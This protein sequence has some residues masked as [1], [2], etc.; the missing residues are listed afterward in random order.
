[1]MKKLFAMLLIAT[2]SLTTVAFAATYRY[3]GDDIVFTYDENIFEIVED[4]H[5]DDE[6]SV[7]L[8]AKDD[9]LGE[10]Y[11]RIH[12]RDLDD[13]E[14][15]PTMAEFI[16]IADVEVTQGDWAGYKDVFMYTVENADGTSQHFFIAPVTDHDGEIED[17]LTVE[18]G[19]T[20][21]EDEDALM[22]RDD[23]ISEIV[24]TLKVDD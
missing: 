10:T 15:F 18:I 3:D 19:V 5:T 12:V 13:G 24:D 16:P 7:V 2:L 23:A 21:I 14:K 20:N 11:V 1:M 9:A 17:I 4:D 6:D 8:A 22:M